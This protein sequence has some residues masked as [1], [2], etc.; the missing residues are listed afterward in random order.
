MKKL[1]FIC[2][3]F[4]LAFP[5][6]AFEENSTEEVVDPYEEQLDILKKIHIIGI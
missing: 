3:A 6:L 5:S 2:V 4:L 1:L